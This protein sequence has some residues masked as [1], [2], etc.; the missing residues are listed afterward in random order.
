M[1]RAVRFIVTL[2]SIVIIHSKQYLSKQPFIYRNL[3]HLKRDVSAMP[4]NLR[5]GV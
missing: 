4:D 3:C 2:H 5:S 1:I